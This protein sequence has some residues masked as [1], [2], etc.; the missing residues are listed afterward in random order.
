MSARPVGGDDAGVRLVRASL[1][2]REAFLDM[3]VEF[4]AEGSNAYP[5]VEYFERYVRRHQR[6]ARRATREFRPMTAYWLMSDDGSAIGIGNLRHDLL[7]PLLA[8][9]RGHI[10]YEIRPSARRKGYGTM[11][12]GL[13][14]TEARVRGLTR[15]LLTCTKDNVGSRTIIERNGGTFESEVYSERL[16]ATMLRFWIE[17]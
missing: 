11:I 8:R 9:E 3:A 15:V 13:L 4:R 14:L 6:L 1:R 5:T 2:Y 7:S 12:L 16:S 10:G 17:L